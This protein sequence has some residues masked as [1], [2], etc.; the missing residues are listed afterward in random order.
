MEIMEFG[1]GAVL[2]YGM[3]INNNPGTF[4]IN[5]SS[6]KQSDFITLR[7]FIQANTGNGK[8]IRIPN[9]PEDRTGATFGHYYIV[10]YSISGDYAPN[11]SITAKE[12]FTDD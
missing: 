4:N 1:D 11:V 9:L 10:A 2:R 7:N 3:G 5:Y 8:A 6:M 12:C